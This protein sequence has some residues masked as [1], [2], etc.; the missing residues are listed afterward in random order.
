MIIEDASLDL[1]CLSTIAHRLILRDGTHQDAAAP[2]L[3]EHSIEAVSYT[4][5]RAHET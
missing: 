1:P 4:H 5:L 2:Y 3:Q